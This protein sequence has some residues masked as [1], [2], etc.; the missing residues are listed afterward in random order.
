MIK[1]TIFVGLGTTGTEILKQLRQL[2]S[3]EFEDFGLPI[4][5]Y[6]SVETRD[7]ETGDNLRHFKDYEEIT[8]V[9]AT[10]ESTASI[11]NR[12]KDDQPVY[13]PHLTDWLSE[14]ILNQIQSFK[15]GASNIRMA[16]RL[17]LWENWTDIQNTLIGARNAIIDHDNQQRT[18]NILRQHYDAKNLPVPTT[19]VNTN[20]IN[21]YV[22]GSLCGGSCSGML[23]DI[24][25]YLRSLL[26]GGTTNNIYGIF[27]MYDRLLAESTHE[28]NSVHAANCYASLS[29]LNYYN[30]AD[31]VYDVTFPSNQEVRTERIPFDYAMYVSPT[32]KLS[33]IRFVA[34][35]AVDVDALNLMVALN[36]FAE[37]VGDTDGQKNQIRTD[38]KS[39]GGYG[40]MKPVPKGKTQKM[41]RGMASFGLTAV[42]YP[43]YR[44]A[45]AAACLSSLNLCKNWMKGHTDDGHTDEATINANVTQVWNNIKGNRNILTESLEKGK[46]ALGNEIDSLLNT[47]TQNFQ[48]ITS[49]NRL[50][51]EMHACPKTRTG[52]D[53]TPT[54]FSIRF[55]QGGKYYEWMQAKVDDC[56]KAFCD[57]ID[58]IFESQINSIDFQG[59]YGLA[60]MR[61]FFNRLDQIIAQEQQRC[62]SDHPTLNLDQLDFDLMGR[63]NN[64]WTRLAGNSEEAVR[65]HRGRLIQEFSQLVK[66]T[67]EGLQ[68][69]FLRQ[70]LQAM[71]AKLGFGVPADGPTIYKQLMQIEENLS[72]CVEA[73]QEQYEFEIVPPTYK[74]VKIVTNDQQDS[75]E[76]D[77]KSLSDQ[78]I[79]DISSE[80][81]L[82]E[83]GN[84]LTMEV[85]LR[86]EHTDITQ[87]I[88]E[89]YQRL[90]LRKINS[91]GDQLGALVVTKAQE[92][93]NA[94]GD[95]DI[96][97]LARRSNP[98][99]EFMHEYQ[100]FNISERGGPKII[101]GHDPS[102][103][104]DSLIDLQ[105]KLSFGRSGNSTVDH[106]L[107]F[108]EEEASFTLDDLAAHN[109]LK[110]HF[111]GS[112]ANFG[113]LTHQDPN[114]YDLTLAE[115]RGK[116][117]RWCR[118]MA[119]LVP[120]IRKSN[121]QAFKNVFEYQNQDIIFIYQTKL[122]P[123]R[124]RMSDDKTGR[125]QLCRQENEAAY[126]KFFNVVKNEFNVLKTE[127]VTQAIK[128]LT[129]KVEDPEEQHELGTFYETFLQEVNPN[130]QAATVIDKSSEKVVDSPL[131]EADPQIAEEAQDKKSGK[132]LSL[133]GRIQQI[134]NKPEKDWTADERFIMQV[135]QQTSGNADSDSAS[136]GRKTIIEEEDTPS[137]E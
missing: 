1:P 89:M 36:L 136:T 61:I 30:H 10:I 25:Y 81:L 60:G 43:K 39:Y 92:I 19:L 93:L 79:D 44:I 56:K 101:F 78:I 119:Q 108:Y 130:F 68:D 127:S 11:R 115:K 80:S 42:W 96:R 135:H 109:A 22:V 94:G 105:N 35:K 33:N 67:A 129:D 9:N 15:D 18:M 83:N 84:E 134:K 47:A 111:E 62:L 122:V 117:E 102:G 121:P 72:K 126:N 50:K 28:E 99:Q 34:D 123:K 70:V 40:G 125:D 45:S 29:E 88:T 52:N 77:A 49:H 16:G 107:F 24:A 98:Y 12:L 65:E 57:A 54:P 17:C 32:G 114:F 87:L 3:E 74:C 46:Q 97:D 110:R 51:E 26:G 31:T 7:A 118:A 128:V 131:S 58:G 2:M 41:V 103:T 120:E 113:H 82:A 6:I 4:F 85:F 95:D 8:V 48:R 124:L 55:N 75:I 86:K 104:K 53:E 132:E 13:N 69:F 76:R 100:A 38:W 37:T 20:G 91:G 90:A 21:G 64:T 5:R 133:E 106:L 63:A 73:L 137:N 14:P 66:K 112:Q 59:T 23:I 27:T 116:L 71:R